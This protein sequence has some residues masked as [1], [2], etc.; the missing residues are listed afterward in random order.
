MAPT[1]GPSHGLGHFKD[2]I[3]PK[4]VKDLQQLYGNFECAYGGMGVR[5]ASQIS[6]LSKGTSAM[7]AA[8]R[9]LAGVNSLKWRFDQN[10]F[11]TLL[12]ERFL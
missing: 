10:D 3:S 1:Q 6:G 9:L 2:E 5:V 11:L 4:L 7:L 8:E 12:S